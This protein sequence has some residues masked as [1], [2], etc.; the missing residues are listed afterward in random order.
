MGILEHKMGHGRGITTALRG[1]PCVEWSEQQFIHRRVK[2]D[3]KLKFQDPYYSLQWHL[4]N[5]DNSGMDVNVL[6]VWKKNITGS[7]VTVAVIDDGIEWT[8]PDL[9][10]NYSPEGS[11]D[12]NSNDPDPMPEF[13]TKGQNHHGTRC[14]GEIAAV[15]NS[16]CAV[17][18]AF[19]AK[20]SGIKILDGPMTD[21]LEAA[22]FNKNMHINDVYSCSWGPDDDGKTIDGPHYLARKALL[23]GVTGGRQ[24]YGSIF[25]VASGNGGSAGDNCNYDGY[26]NSI[27][28]VTIGAVDETGGIP[29]Y[30]ESCSS[31]LAVTFSSGD[32]FH[33]G[34]VTTDWQMGKGTGCTT[35]HSGTS[36][37]APLAA[38]MVA[39]M[40]QINRQSSEWTVNAAGFYHS[41]QHGFGLMDAWRLVNAAKVWEP[42]S[43][44]MSLN[45]PTLHE[46][47]VFTGGHTV[48]FFYNV[49]KRD[50]DIHFLYSLEYVLVTVS[51]SH[52]SR[53]NLELKLVCP[54]GTKSVIA[55]ARPKDKS[56]D[57]IK[58][59]T[60][61]TVRCWGE[62]AVGIWE[63]LITDHGNPGEGWGKLEHWKLT[64]YGSS[65]TPANIQAR[66]EMVEDAMDGRF[67]NSNHSAPCPPPEPPAY[68]ETK[69]IRVK[70]L[71][72]LVLTGGMTVLLALYYTVEQAFLN[73]ED[74][75]G[76]PPP[77]NPAPE[78]G[79]RETD[80]LIPQQDTPEEIPMQTLPLT[81]TVPKDTANIAESVASNDTAD[82]SP[83]LE[84]RPL[85]SSRCDV[86][87]QELPGSATE[88]SGLMSPT[89]ETY[90]NEMWS[91]RDEDVLNVSRQDNRS[92]VVLELESSEK[93]W[94]E[95][96]LLA[97]DQE[98]SD[99]MTQL[100]D[101]AD[102][103]VLPV[104]EQITVDL[105]EHS[106]TSGPIE[107]ETS[108]SEQSARQSL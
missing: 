22:A 26:A 64:L 53:G 5:R 7:G 21:N 61:S 16:V 59:W 37:A 28:T 99:G 90:Q 13:D 39:L 82:N 18:V 71:K 4:H 8:N 58:E 94:E 2:R 74:K 45:S 15:A 34:I 48:K 80:R 73:K 42:V 68:D 75:E 91:A 62:A 23:Y 49:T 32:A 86:Q 66:R 11:F 77:I 40:L 36:A 85:L 83:A 25:V 88:D 70:T 19:H 33:K 101:L 30:A 1:H 54:S 63:L 72:I 69:A 104:S 60:F 97:V 65:L 92:S 100:D 43:W 50:A 9:Q 14:A 81:E 20:I 27:Y 78:G 108:S 55:A 31:M 106:R 107:E 56:K 12:L 102:Q 47:Y 51:V 46:D 38:G 41:H 76:V 103:C 93:D 24:G 35:G 87:I 44:L 10:D 96:P 95:Q 17:G 89:S 79:P 67:L 57:G 52:S 6:N 84:R 3:I 29:Y 105:Q 98:V